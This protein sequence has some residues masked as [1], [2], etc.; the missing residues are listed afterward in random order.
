MIFGCWGCGGQGG[1][2]LWGSGD[3]RPMND[4]D[5]PGR[6]VV[7]DDGGA[8]GGWMGTILFS[9]CCHLDHSHLHFVYNIYEAQSL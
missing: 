7:M 1:G 6:G 4:T 5:D 8:G 9:L 3:E 2:D